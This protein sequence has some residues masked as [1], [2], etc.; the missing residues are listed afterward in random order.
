M[1]IRDSAGIEASGGFVRDTATNKPCLDQFWD[2]WGAHLDFTRAADRK[3][4]Q[5]GFKKQVLDFG[6]DTGWN[7]NNEYEIW[8]ET[9]QSDGHGTPIP[10]HRS[11]AL[12]ALLMTQATSCLLYTSRCV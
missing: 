4:W 10:I 11:R 2:G 9:G 8:S 5:D 7:D 3:W 6:I 1:C 12:Q